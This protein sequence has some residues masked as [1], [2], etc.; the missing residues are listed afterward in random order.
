MDD[1]LKFATEREKEAYSY[2]QKKYTYKKIGELMCISSERV[3][4]LYVCAERRIKAYEK[5]CEIQRKEKE[6]F[7]QPI[8]F[9]LSYGEGK[10]ISEA[11]YDSIR[12]YEK[13]YRVK[14][15]FSN[16]N[17][18]ANKSKLPYEYFLI[19]DLYERLTKNL[20]IPTNWV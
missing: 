2:R 9:P 6:K 14:H 1:K 5:Y 15:D 18:E 12:T 4:Q 11:L 19:R 13:E 20:G 16:P 10:L 17:F 3:R 7:A 8:D